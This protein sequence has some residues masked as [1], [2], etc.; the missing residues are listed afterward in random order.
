MRAVILATSTLTGMGPLLRYRPS[1]LLHIA[2]K[3]ILF[4]VME[5]LHKEKIGSCDLFISEFAS[6]IEDMIGDGRRWGIDITIY[7]IR[8]SMLPFEVLAPTAM[9]WKQENVLFGFGDC[10]PD[11]N[12]EDLHEPVLF[13][14]ED[15]TWTGWGIIPSSQ[16]AQF[17]SNSTIEDIP[18]QLHIPKKVVKTSLSTKTLTDLK[19]S[20]EN[21]LKSET[22]HT[23]L[24]TARM[25][26]PQIWI[27][28][29][30]SMRKS[31]NIVPPAFIGENCQLMDNVQ[32]GPNAV[33]ESHCI[34]DKGSTV[35]NSIVCQRSYV[36][37]GLSIHDCIVDRNTL[38]D[39]ALD[40]H[41]RIRDDFILSSLATPSLRNYPI[42][43]LERVIA[44]I[45]I[46]I[47][48]PVLLLMYL[49]YPLKSHSFLKIPA[50]KD[51]V[52]WET[53]NWHY[54]EMP[55]NPSSL[56]SFFQ[57]FSVLIN[58]MQGDVHF[59]GVA[60]RSLKDALNLPLDRQNLYL[61]SKIGL[62]TLSNLDHGPAA[63][64]DEQYA[65]EIYYAIH[66]STGFDLKLIM[67][68]IKSKIKMIIKF[69]KNIVMSSSH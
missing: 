49:V 47:L 8:D 30:V 67:R 64:P 13:Y 56:G 31:T 2:D 61:K 32:I 46:V 51:P 4:Y 10:L 55:E 54:F 50:S 16:L 11:L 37:E 69:L 52:R 43:F 34:I 66:M 5:L 24:S 53:F 14:H 19:N 22:D 40:T 68:W 9:G 25:V 15:G 62:I 7:L 23:K 41:I 36:G 1:C 12:N 29:A 57:R 63:T 45:L 38:I 39:L 26:E 59:V 60:P 48:S 35:Q 44:L 58:I 27:S 33:I 3:P 42:F 28:R 6:K 65:S 21:I 20:N 18:N 17:S